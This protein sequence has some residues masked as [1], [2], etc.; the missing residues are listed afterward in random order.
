MSANFCRRFARWR[1]VGA[2]GIVV[3]CLAGC[4]GSPHAEPSATLPELWQTQFNQALDNPNLSA[5]QRQVL[6]DYVV[7]DG[8]Y[9]DAWRQFVSCMSDRGWSVELIDGGGYSVT[10]APGSGHAVADDAS[11]DNDACMDQYLGNVELLYLGVK[12]NPQGIVG[13]SREALI[14]SCFAAHGVPDGAGMSDDEFTAMVRQWDY[15]ASTPEGVLC[16][17]DPDGSQ[18][19]TVAQAQQMDAE[20]R[21]VSEIKPDGTVYCNGVQCTVNPDKTVDCGGVCNITLPP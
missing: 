19:M 17:W 21:K 1:V 20:P 12:A 18:G 13:P 8:E 2:V 6:S 4:T 9:Q 10:A 14:R 5:Y 3:A 7:T 15:H 16:Y 11:V